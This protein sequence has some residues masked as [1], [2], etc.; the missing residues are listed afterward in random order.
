[1]RKQQSHDM[2][3]FCVLEHFF[4][5]AKLCT[6]LCMNISVCIVLDNLLIS[7]IFTFRSNRNMMFKQHDAKN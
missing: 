4:R 3:L 1:M 6:K 5:F 7:K 2:L